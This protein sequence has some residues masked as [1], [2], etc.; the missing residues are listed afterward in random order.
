MRLERRTAEGEWTPTPETQHLLRLAQE[1]RDRYLATQNADALT[2]AAAYWD[3]IVAQPAFVSA[4]PGFRILAQNNAGATYDRLYRLFRRQEHFEAAVRYYEAGLRI[5]SDKDMTRSLLYGLGVIYA[6]RF[7][8]LHDKRDLEKSYYYS[9]QSCD[10]LH[11]EEPGA[12]PLLMNHICNLR[13]MHKINGSCD[14]LEQA[15]SL[16]REALRVA[17]CSRT[18][19]Q[20]EQQNLAQLLRD[21]FDL[22]KN[23]EDLAEAEELC[24]YK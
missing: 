23:P 19:G 2:E 16:A 17:A 14:L 22:L 12:L 5:S 20:A 15:I 11:A 7:A 8:S 10:G 3:L 24:R 6:E 4:S 1:A 13:E 21:R 9:T 18:G